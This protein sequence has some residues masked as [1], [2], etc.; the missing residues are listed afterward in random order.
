VCLVITLV[1][2]IRTKFD[3]EGVLLIPADHNQR[4]GREVLASF[5]TISMT[6]PEERAPSPF[7]E[8]IC[9][10]YDFTNTS[11][12]I[13][14]CNF[15]WCEVEAGPASEAHGQVQQDT[16]ECYEKVES[17][18]RF[19]LENVTD[20]QRF[21]G[22]SESQINDSYL[23][24]GS[25]SDRST[26]TVAR[27]APPLIGSNWEMGRIALTQVTDVYNTFQSSSG[28]HR[29][30]GSRILC[31]C[32]VDTCQL[33]EEWSYLSTFPVERS[34]S[35]FNEFLPEPVERSTSSSNES[36]PEPVE[37][38][39]PIQKLAQVHVVMGIRPLEQAK[40]E[41]GAFGKPWQFAD[42]NMDELWTQRALLSICRDSGEAF[43]VVSKT[44][45]LEDFWL[46]MLHQNGRFPVPQGMFQTLAFMFLNNSLVTDGVDYRK[47]LWMK[48]GQIQAWYYSFEVDVSNITTADEVAAYQAQWQSFAG[49]QGWVVSEL[50]DTPPGE[51]GKAEEEQPSGSLI[52]L[53]LVLLVVILGALLAAWEM[54][55][56][57]IA[58]LSTICNAGALLFLDAVVLDLEIGVTEICIIV[59]VAGYSAMF[60]LRM[61]LAYKSPAAQNFNLPCTYVAEPVPTPTPQQQCASFAL[62]R[63]GSV[64]L[65]TAFLGAGCS[66]LM[67]LFCSLRFFRL[68]GAMALTGVLVAAGFAL[69]PAPAAL[70]LLG[71]IQLSG[72]RQF[73]LDLFRCQLQV[74]ARRD[75]RVMEG[76]AGRA[77]NPD[78]VFHG[79]LTV[80]GPSSSKKPSK[81]RD[82]E[83]SGAAS[84]DEKPPTKR[85]KLEHI[86]GTLIRI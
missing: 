31:F 52:V 15:L 30:C 67:L 24:R 8:H 29:S 4:Y 23:L 86:G 13:L 66:L 70:A 51:D 49:A 62:N 58:A 28:D 20:I 46:W 1:A 27:S 2:L 43:S 10:D 72:C 80:P 41:Q 59:L 42:F 47:F 79:P 75:R 73:V 21:I 61:A 45:W 50:W 26:A 48:G 74:D 22:L 38:P 37:A 17:E 60:T 85:M 82:V 78:I 71:E 36:L 33:Q 7:E 76:P 63:A 19:P 9:R 6:F 57:S 11:D 12:S 34:T 77:N 84:L 83:P 54:R 32:G 69:G 68:I 39:K 81:H 5:S 14:L 35:S 44:C 53:A 65:G 3:G 18:C 25:F 64:I 40:L 16:C 55:A 56:A